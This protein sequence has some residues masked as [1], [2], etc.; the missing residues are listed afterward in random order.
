MIV[1]DA[2]AVIEVL[3]RS[4]SAGSAGAKLFG[5]GRSLHAPH[6]IDVEIT[7]AFRRLAALGEISEKRGPIMLTLLTDMPI[8]R[9]AHALLLPRAWALRSNVTAYDAVYVAL[10]E[11][12]NAPLVT[13]DSRLARA[14]SH[15]VAVELV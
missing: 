11:V 8:R 1:L 4:A 14:V 15:L 12:L 3:L 13:R 2:S 7:H 6:L 9:Y 5:S 10:A